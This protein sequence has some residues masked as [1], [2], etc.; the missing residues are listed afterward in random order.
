MGAEQREQPSD[1]TQ[2]KESL[3]ATPSQLVTEAGVLYSDASAA[4]LISISPQPLDRE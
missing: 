3:R 1:P 4:E 2:R